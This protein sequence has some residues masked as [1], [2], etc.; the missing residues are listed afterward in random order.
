[1]EKVKNFTYEIVFSSNDW[2][3]FRMQ[4]SPQ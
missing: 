4:K 2:S 3:Y 1:V